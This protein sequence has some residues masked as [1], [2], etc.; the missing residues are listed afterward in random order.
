MRIF[1]LTF[2]LTSHFSAFGADTLVRING[3]GA[4]FPYPPLLKMVRHL[5]PG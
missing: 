2:L 3:A 1:F 5:Q 4:T